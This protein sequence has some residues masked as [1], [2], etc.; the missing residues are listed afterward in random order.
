MAFPSECDTV[1]LLMIVCVMLQRKQRDRPHAIL[2]STLSV[3]KLSSRAF[4]RYL[5]C[6]YRLYLGSVYRHVIYRWKALEVTFPVP[7]FYTARYQSKG[8]N[9]LQFGVAK[10]TR[11]TVFSTYC[12]IVL[13]NTKYQ[14]PGNFREF[15][16]G[17]TLATLNGQ[18]FLNNGPIW[19]N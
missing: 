4:Q 2:C 6:L 3:K 7:L 15:S 11:L 17:Q 19:T 16:E 13:Q 14:H 12:R 10:L 18:N 5:T 8:P 9:L 1:N